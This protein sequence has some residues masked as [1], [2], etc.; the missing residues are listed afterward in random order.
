MLIGVG[1]EQDERAGTRWDLP[2]Y[3]RSFFE[4]TCGLPAYYPHLGIL[5]LILGHR[6]K[7][8][9]NSIPCF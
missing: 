8:D 5:F 3:S 2:P 4:L 9:S 1:L 6:E 7:S